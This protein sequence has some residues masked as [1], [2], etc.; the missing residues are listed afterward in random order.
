[1]CGMNVIGYDPAINVASRG[2]PEIMAKF[3]GD[4]DFLI[5]TASLNETTKE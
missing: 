5:I 1:M 2:C 3:V 4:A